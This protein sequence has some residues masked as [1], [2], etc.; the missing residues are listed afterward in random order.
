MSKK[1]DQKIIL[2]ILK[3][4]EFKLKKIKFQKKKKDYNKLRLRAS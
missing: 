3:E 2:N 4:F 1:R